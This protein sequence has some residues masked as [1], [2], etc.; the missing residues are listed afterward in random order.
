MG[1]PHADF[2]FLP[3]HRLRAL[4]TFFFFFF[5]LLCIYPFQTRDDPCSAPQVRYPFCVVASLSTLESVSASCALARL[6]QPAGVYLPSLPIVATVLFSNEYQRT[7]YDAK[8]TSSPV[9]SAFCCLFY[10]R[11]RAPFIKY[12][13]DRTVNSEPIRF[14]FPLR[15]WTHRSPT[16]PLWPASR[17]FFFLGVRCFSSKPARFLLS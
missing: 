4:D 10:P 12:S 17:L 14:F 1:A 2:R 15:F 5:I 16:L 11:R 6:S 9:A 7:L 8:L 3:L 13:F